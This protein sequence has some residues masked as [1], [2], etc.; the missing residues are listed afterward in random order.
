MVAEWQNQ[1]QILESQNHSV[2]ELEGT[3]PAITQG[4]LL[5]EPESTYK[6]SEIPSS[7][8]LASSNGEKLTT[9]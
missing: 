8:C 1:S 9:L 3:L 7:F 2:T 6:T 4:I 5:S